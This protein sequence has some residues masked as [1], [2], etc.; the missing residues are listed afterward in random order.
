M[1]DNELEPMT[2]NNYFKLGDFVVRTE[3]REYSIWTLKEM[4]KPRRVISVNSSCIGLEGMPYDERQSHPGWAAK[5]FRHATPDEISDASDSIESLLSE[6]DPMDLYDPVY[7]EPLE[8]SRDEMS[9][10]IDAAKLEA[11]LGHQQQQLTNLLNAVSAQATKIGKLENHPEQYM[12]QFLQD[13]ITGK[14]PYILVRSAEIDERGRLPY[15]GG[16]RQKGTNNQGYNWRWP[17]TL[18]PVPEK[19]VM[20]A[21][22]EDWW[23]SK[24]NNRYY[25]LGRNEAERQA[26]LRAEIVETDHKTDYKKLRASSKVINAVAV[27]FTIA[28]TSSVWCLVSSYALL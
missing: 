12:G 8:D 28:I 9:Q 11:T 15:Y 22:A 1:I 3:P 4:R 27:I 16:L 10:D 5:W 23:K 6:L 18:E 20:K 17:E 2:A 24:L 21:E 26:E 14:G 25:Y 13:K 7:D 19:G